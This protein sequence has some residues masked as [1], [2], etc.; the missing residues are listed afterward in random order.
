VN[1]LLNFD[2]MVTPKFIS[3]FYWLLLLFVLVSGLGVMFTG[4]VLG[5][6]L[7]IVIGAIGVRVWC[8]L[9]IVMFKIHENIKKIAERGDSAL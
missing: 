2:T 1:E 5:G 3:V 8:E 7:A 9:L 6:L 4:S